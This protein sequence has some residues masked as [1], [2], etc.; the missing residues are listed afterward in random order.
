MQV[1]I[2][3]WYETPNNKNLKSK[4]TVQLILRNPNAEV[5]MCGK[6]QNSH[7]KQKLCA[8]MVGNSAVVC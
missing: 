1:W 6:K 3:I 5:S 7:T 4:M 8:E 2:W